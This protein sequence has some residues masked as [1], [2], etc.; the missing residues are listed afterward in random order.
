MIVLCCEGY[1]S[2]LAAASLAAL[3]YRAADVAGGFERW[4]EAGLP[5]IP[6]PTPPR[7]GLPGM[8][9]PDA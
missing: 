1:S 5:V 3:G 4:R 8:Q 7:D 9:P 6:A 2:I